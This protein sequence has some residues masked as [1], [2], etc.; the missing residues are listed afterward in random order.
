[1]LW[2]WLILN[3]ASH[4]RTSFWPWRTVI[5]IP[6]RKIIWIR[7]GALSRLLSLRRRDC[8]RICQNCWCIQWILSTTTW[9]VIDH[10]NDCW[11][12]MIGHHFNHYLHDYQF[13]VGK[14]NSWSNSFDFCIPLHFYVLLIVL[15]NSN[16]Y[17]Q[18]SSHPLG[19]IAT[20]EGAFILS[21]ALSE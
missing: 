4:T 1:M 7:G 12:L 9:Q 10:V 21:T 8:C 6:S 18:N 13:A 20:K 3:G 11:W 5:S 16:E 15:E 17:R 2:L 14:P 19:I